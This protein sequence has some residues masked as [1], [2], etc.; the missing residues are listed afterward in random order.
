M[1][2]VN[3]NQHGI[4]FFLKIFPNPNFQQLFQDSAYVFLKSNYGAM[5]PVTW[6]IYWHHRFSKSCNFIFGAKSG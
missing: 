2:K 4:T 6:C 1:L 3:S 5:F